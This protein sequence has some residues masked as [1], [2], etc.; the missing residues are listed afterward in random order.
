MNF[1]L[2][3]LELKVLKCWDWKLSDT[4]F[5][6]KTVIQIKEHGNNTH[7]WL[8]KSVSQR[9]KVQQTSW[10]SLASARLMYLNVACTI[11]L[12]FF[13]FF[14]SQTLRRHTYDENK[15]LSL[16]RAY[17]DLYLFFGSLL[18]CFARILFV[19]NLNIYEQIMNFKWNSVRRVWVSLLVLRVNSKFSL[20]LRNKIYKLL[21]ILPIESSL[22]TLLGLQMSFLKFIS[23]SYVHVYIELNIY[24]FLY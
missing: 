11:V 2:E 20:R 8:R 9:E 18:A 15:M 1:T 21:K 23:K 10:I 7:W 3:T 5:V 14:K 24:F 4:S 12:L 16:E 17:R 6:Q 22:A 19:F 13:S